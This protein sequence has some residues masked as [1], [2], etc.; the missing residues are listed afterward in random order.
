MFRSKKSV[1][2]ALTSFSAMSAAV[3]LAAP[4]AP[5]AVTAIGL[6]PGMSFGTSTAYG[7]NCTYIATATATPGDV[8]GFVDPLGTFD[9]AGWITVPSSGTV[10]ARWTPLVPGNHTVYAVHNSNAW[11][12]TAA[13]VGNGVNLGFACVV[14]P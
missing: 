4:A 9:P 13:T 7:T 3:V 12:S 2:A 1:A 10:T 6:A 8:I 14:L 11:V 5:A